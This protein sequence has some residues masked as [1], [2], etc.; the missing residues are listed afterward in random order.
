MTVAQLI[1]QLQALPQDLPVCLG[2]EGI[3]TRHVASVD[4]RDEVLENA[5]ERIWHQPKRVVL[6]ERA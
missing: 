5:A 2:Y 3:D 6:D 1:E 4:V